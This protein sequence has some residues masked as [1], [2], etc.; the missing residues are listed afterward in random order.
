MWSAALM[1]RRNLA[2]WNPVHQRP[3]VGRLPEQ[4]MFR[5]EDP[6]DLG[7]RKCLPHPCHRILVPVLQDPEDCVVGISFRLEGVQVR[8]PEKSL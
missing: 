2:G 7:L 4:T 6:S 3:I 1:K 5:A 8:V